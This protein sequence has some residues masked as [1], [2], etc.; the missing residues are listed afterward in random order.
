MRVAEERAGLVLLQAVR[1]RRREVE[2]RERARR[3][4]Q[5]C[6]ASGERGEWHA[7]T[8]L[9]SGRDE[10]GKGTR[11]EREGERR[12]EGE[13]RKEKGTRGEGAKRIREAEEIGKTERIESA[14]KAK[15]PKTQGQRGKCGGGEHVE[16]GKK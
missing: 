9:A 12:R 14:G 11:R 1:G 8:D 5:R 4:M 15:N 10:R 16:N 13:K 6:A 2:A 7:V 3:R